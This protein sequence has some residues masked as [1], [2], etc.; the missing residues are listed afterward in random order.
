MFV[1]TIKLSEP[2]CDDPDDDKFIA[3]AISGRAKYIVSGD[4]HLLKEFGYAGLKIVTPRQYLDR[5]L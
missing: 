2:V 5:Y 3:C 4:K 1:E